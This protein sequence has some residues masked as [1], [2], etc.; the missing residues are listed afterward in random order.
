LYK[1]TWIE[2]SGGTIEVRI[3]MWWNKVE[4]KEGRE[5]KIKKG[6][7]IPVTGRGGP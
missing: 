1:E 5:N 6:K 3:K 2:E 4:G 7:A